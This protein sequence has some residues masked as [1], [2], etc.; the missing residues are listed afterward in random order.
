MGVDAIQPYMGRRILEVGAGISNMSRLPVRERLVLADRAG[1]LAVLH[2]RT[3]SIS[4]MPSHEWRGFDLGGRRPMQLSSKAKRSIRSCPSTCSA[5][6]ERMRHRAA[7]HTPAISDRQV[8]RLVSF[9]PPRSHGPSVRWIATMGTSA[10]IRPGGSGK[11]G[12]ELAPDAQLSLRS[13]N[14]IGLLG[15]VWT[16]MILKRGVI[17][18]GSVKAF[19]ALPLR[20]NAPTVCRT[21]GFPSANRSCGF[22]VTG[23]ASLDRQSTP[24]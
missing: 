11:S 9:V 19:D 13:F 21:L 7:A 14:A 10:G 12:R 5:H 15:W 24:G 4:G 20:E 23:R 2:A 17:D 16:T 3:R 8:R 18:P 22:D 1:V 6:R